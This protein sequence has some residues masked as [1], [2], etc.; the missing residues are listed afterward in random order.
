[1]IL[2]QTRGVLSSRDGLSL[3]LPFAETKSLTARVGPTPTFTRA[4]TG[5]FVGSNGLIQ[6]SG[7]NVARF[8]HDPV[9]L[10]SRGLLIEES[11]ANL[12]TRSEELSTTPWGVIATTTIAI[13]DISSPS[14]SIT[15][16][17]II[18]GATTQVYGI[19]NNTVS[20]VNG[21]SY[22]VSFFV[23][24]NQVTRVA[25]YSNNTTL[26]PISAI[27]DLTG[28]GSIVGT[29]TG[30]ASIQ[31]LPN[32][33]YRCVVAGVALSSGITSIRLSPIS[34]T[35]ANYP[36]NSVDSFYAWGAQLEVG[37][38]A[39]SYIPTTTASV[40]RS[41]DVCSIS[42]A[43]FTGIWNYDEGTI[44]AAFDQAPSNAF[45]AILTAA[46]FDDTGKVQIGRATRSQIYLAIKNNAN[47]E[48]FVYNPTSSITAGLNKSALAYNTNDAIGTINNLFSP[49]DTSVSL[50]TPDRLL[51]ANDSVGSGRRHNGHI[52]AVRVYK[53]RLPLSKLQALTA[54]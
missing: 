18:V 50:G 20:F 11:R 12:W 45:S 6:S 21:T 26:L 37:S 13:D 49:L 9:T 42:G 44:Y 38:F 22:S 32:G 14:G 52:S 7:N 41:A 15:A 47:T 23:K 54:P 10:A 39:T 35:S 33:W 28:S 19:F 48:T 29:P 24:A 46:R 36:G 4:S 27:F 16:E 5:T 3:D 40:V 2:Q 25:I 51:I 30:I 43:G 8:D 34:G 1:M 31:Q 17:R 53:K